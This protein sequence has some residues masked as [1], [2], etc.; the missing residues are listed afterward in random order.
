M[1]VK[2]THIKQ[3]M[4]LHACCANCLMH[5]Y[6]LLKDSFDITVYFYNPNI[7]PFD[8]YD[9]RLADVKRVCQNLGIKMHAGPYDCRRWFEYTDI[10]TGEPEGGK[11]CSLCFYKRLK[12]TAVLAKKC[13][14]D[15][16]ATTLSVSPHKNADVINK[17]AEEISSDT[18]ISYYF[19]NF[20]KKDGFKKTMYM[21]SQFNVYRQKY[22]GCVYSM[23]KS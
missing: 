5:P 11:R 1:H 17:V 12:R 19:S 4:L 10:Y 18:G 7:H 8:E 20:K 23:K 15:I 6:Q 2:K 16:F 13:N 3:K 22:C 14:F 9:K 21:A